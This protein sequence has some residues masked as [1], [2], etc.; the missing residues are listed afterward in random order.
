[1]RRKQEDLAGMP[2]SIAR[3]LAQ[4]GDVWTLMVLREAFQGSKR[5]DD[6]VV[7]LGIATNVLSRLLRQLCDAGIL[8]KAEYNAHPPRFEYLLTQKGRDLLPALMMLASWGDKYLA[9][10]YAPREWVHEAC[11]H[12]GLPALV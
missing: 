8:E 11:G 9:E 3:T 1:M 6:F 5:F 7:N 10:D 12:V 4:L 2:C